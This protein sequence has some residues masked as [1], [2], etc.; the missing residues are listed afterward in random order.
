MVE[1]VAEIIEMTS[2]QR[3]MLVDTRQ[4]WG[5]YREAYRRRQS[6]E[7]GLTWKTVKGREYLVRIYSDAVSKAKKQTSLGLRSP[8]TERVFAEFRD[9]KADASER[10]ASL[11]RRLEEQARLNKAVD[12]GRVPT[13]SAR[14]LRMLDRAGLLGR[15]VFVGGTH[16]M[17]AY[18]SAAGVFI[19]RDLMTTGDLDLLMEAR[20]K[21]K[22]SV[23]GLDSGGL[24]GLL[25]R[26]DKSFERA[27]STFRAVNRD[28]FYID[29]IKA[30]PTPPWKNERDAFGGGG[31]LAASPIANMKWV[32]NAPRFE[33]VAVGEDGMPVPMACPD[34]RAFALYK[35]WMG[36]Q[37]AS[38]D[39]VK[40]R[41]DVAQAETIARIVHQWLPHL[42]FEPEHLAC[43]PR[44]AIN[45]ASDRP[46]PFF[47]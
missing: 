38:R 24:L 30:Q 11:T 7:G 15:N 43:F 33:A 41:R 40:R 20:A 1:T 21:L 35:L 36:T 25:Q 6:F 34:P 17:F 28:G 9:G 12:L 19:E 8:E 18:E 46:D 26:V 45:L 5:A 44:A 2:N 32:A 39:P 31:D 23:D 3:R 4:V 42:P 27:S 22:L 14:V 47:R 37:D 10:L 29:L 16:S 13:V